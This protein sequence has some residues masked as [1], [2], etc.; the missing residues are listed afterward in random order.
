MFPVC[1]NFLVSIAG[2]EAS[3]V[4]NLKVTAHPGFALSDSSADLPEHQQ[5]VCSKY[6][7]TQAWF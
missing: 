6:G 5:T 1:F 7:N 3:R 4:D 2:V